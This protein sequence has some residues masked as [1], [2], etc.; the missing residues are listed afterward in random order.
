M[1]MPA[2]TYYVGDLCY[3]MR[4]EWNEV[5]DLCF[6][7]ESNN[8]VEGILQLE[9]GRKFAIFNTEYGDGTY[10]SNDY[11][12][13]SVDAGSIGCILRSDITDPDNLNIEGLGHYITYDEDFE[14]YNN[15][16]TIT[17]GKLEIYTADF[18]EDED[19]DEDE[20]YE[21]Y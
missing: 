16:G 10:A 2:G 6:P 11:K 13:F 7:D 20:E 3:V 8:S 15:N 12:S 14:V 9:D 4:N 21:D 17:F 18:D 19:E 5:C 1:M